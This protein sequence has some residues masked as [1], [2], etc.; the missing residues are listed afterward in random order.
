MAWED[1]CRGSGTLGSP[2]FRRVPKLWTSGERRPRLES[3]CKLMHLQRPL[4]VELG[5]AA[6]AQSRQGRG[7]VFRGFGICD[8]ESPR[9]DLPWPDKSEGISTLLRKHQQA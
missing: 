8:P 9:F 6:N 2:A 5:P 4:L 1:F 7:V 3:T